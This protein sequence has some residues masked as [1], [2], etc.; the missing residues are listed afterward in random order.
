MV[1]TIRRLGLVGATLAFLFIAGLN[2]SALN[3]QWDVPY[4]GVQKANAWGP[5]V[6]GLCWTS[7]LP[8]P[9]PRPKCWRIDVYVVDPCATSCPKC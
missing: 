7:P 3:R 4:L 8:M 6:I 9:L 5:C 1:R 2:F